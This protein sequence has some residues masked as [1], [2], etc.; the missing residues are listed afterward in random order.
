MQLTTRKKY[1]LATLVPFLFLA[2]TIL[3]FGFNYENNDDTTMVS[4]LN[5]SYSGTPDGHAIFIKYALGWIIKTLYCIPLP[6]NWYAAVMLGIYLFAMVFLLCQFLNRF[7]RR[8]ALVCALYIGFISALWIMQISWFTFSTC[9]AFVTAAVSLSYA[10]IPKEEDL[11]PGKLV[12][13]ILLLCLSYNIRKQFVLAALLI[14]AIVWLSKYYDRMFK[15][16]KCWIIPIAGVICLALCIGCNTIAYSS[17][18]WQEYIDY[19]TQRAMVQDYYGTP[20]YEENK[21]YYDALGYSDLD[22]RSM[23]QYHYMLLDD[24]STDYFR[25]V[26]ELAKSQQEHPSLFQLIKKTVK[27]T[28]KHYLL[29]DKEDWGPIQVLSILAPVSLVL[30]ALILSWKDRR[31]YWI[32]SFLLLAGLGCMWLYITYNGRY[33]ERVS[34]S[35]RIITIAAS[36][37]GISILLDDHPLHMPKWTDQ[38]PGRVALYALAAVT[39]FCGAYATWQDEGFADYQPRS[40]FY[41]YTDQHPENIYIRDTTLSFDNDQEDSPS[42]NTLSTGGWLHYSPLYDQKLAQFGLDK[43]NRSSL[44]LPNVYLIADEDSSL[45]RL[46]GLPT[47]TPLDYEL[48]EQFDT[49]CIYHFNSIG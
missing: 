7:P 26:Y 39:L 2:A 16:F 17:Q 5:G 38:V 4:I 8:P 10:L 23:K 48:V 42:V 1:L 49:V 6:I 29:C 14:L 22:L 45:H 35:L 28:I 19:N 27:T 13:L 34:L 12:P 30:M 3:I 47:D 46:L 11:K 18:D 31:H 9:G 21:E 43:I 41:V 37:A 20:P 44:L 36:L 25:D 32:F 40:L 24:F 33:L 15:E